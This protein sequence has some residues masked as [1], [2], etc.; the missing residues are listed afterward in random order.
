MQVQGQVAYP[1]PFDEDGCY[2]AFPTRRRRREHLEKDCVVPRVDLPRVG[3]SMFLWAAQ[4]WSEE[5]DAVLAR[6]E[7]T[8]E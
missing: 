4:E 1:C 5:V 6:L 3:H 8:D 2:H 7:V